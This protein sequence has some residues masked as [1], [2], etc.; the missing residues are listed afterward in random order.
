M[1]QVLP[2]PVSGHLKSLLSMHHPRCTLWETSV[3]CVWKKKLLARS[4]WVHVISGIKWTRQGY[5]STSVQILMLLSVYLGWLLK[6]FNKIMLN[7]NEVG[8]WWLGA[9]LPKWTCA[10]F[11]SEMVKQSWCYYYNLWVSTL[12]HPVCIFR[13]RRRALMRLKCQVVCHF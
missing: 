9:D 2:P 7:T 3:K 11:L 13:Q 1:V 5:E 6:S 12:P 10:T 8:C 4:S